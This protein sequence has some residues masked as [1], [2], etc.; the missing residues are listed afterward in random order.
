MSPSN[1]ESKRRSYTRVCWYLAFISIVILISGS[2]V[3]VQGQD[4]LLFQLITGTLA[5]LF[6]LLAIY[7]SSRGISRNTDTEEK[8]RFIGGE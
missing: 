7:R 4:P 8:D 2:L 6:L 5:G 1:R 3:D